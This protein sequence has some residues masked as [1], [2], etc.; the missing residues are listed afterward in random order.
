MA[1]IFAVDDILSKE[2]A[3][4]EGKVGKGKKRSRLKSTAPREKR[5]KKRR[6]A[7]YFGVASWRRLL[8]STSRVVITMLCMQGKVAGRSYLGYVLRSRAK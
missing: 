5:K 1:D 7:K 8:R 6:G 3:G 2:V 4:E